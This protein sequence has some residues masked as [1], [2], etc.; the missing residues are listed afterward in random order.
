MRERVVNDADSPLDGA[1]NGLT[2]RGLIGG[3]LALTGA[4]A[5]GAL[6][7]NAE[8]AESRISNARVVKMPDHNLPSGFS[9]T[10]IEADVDGV[11]TVVGSAFFLEDGRAK[12]EFITKKANPKDF[13]PDGRPQFES[14]QSEVSARGDKVVL[15][16]AGAF[17]KSDGQT[18]GIAL[19]N[20]QMV[21][22]AA[23]ANELN[24]ILVIKNGVPSIEYLNQ[25]PDPQAF[26]EQAKREGWSLFQQTSYLRPGGKFQSSNPSSYELRFFA[27]GEGKKAVVNFTEKMTYTEAVQALQNLAGF[28]IEKAIGLDTGA[29]SEARFFDKDGKPYTMVDEQFGQ[30]RGYTNVLALYSDL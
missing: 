23:A 3:L 18:K 27:E 19:E 30:G 17:F 9:R 14:I 13:G 20:G 10:R 26:F 22:E 29:V 2:R 21:G 6:P 8:A 24:G 4:A 7:K 28:K 11:S 25:L 1:P 12:A 5:L 15:V 16:G